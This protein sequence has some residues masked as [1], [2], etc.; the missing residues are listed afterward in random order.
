MSVV[1]DEFAPSS[2][3]ATAPLGL[4]SPPGLSLPNK[5]QEV[6]PEMLQFINEVGLE[7]TRRAEDFASSHLT[8]DNETFQFEYL[9]SEEY[10]ANE[11]FTMLPPGLSPPSGIYEDCAGTS[12][13]D[14]NEDDNEMQSTTG[15]SD[16][17]ESSDESTKADSQPDD[18]AK[19]DSNADADGSAT[20]SVTSDDEEEE[21]NDEV[22][23]LPD[24][25][26]EAQSIRKRKKLQAANLTKATTR[27]VYGDQGA[28]LAAQVALMGCGYG[29]AMTWQP[30]PNAQAYG[31]HPFYGYI[32]WS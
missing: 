31:W 15:K 20:A 18:S 12:S 24:L 13:V 27:I 2:K 4:S 7:L 17:N 5:V 23:E 8:G 26:T 11:Y 3:D 22:P 28:Q 30:P 21:S 14:G 1:F 29:G 6:T 19:A 10:L 9:A 25:S 16:G 32:A